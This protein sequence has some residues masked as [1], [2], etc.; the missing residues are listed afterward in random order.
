MEKGIYGLMALAACMTVS[1][2]SDEPSDNNIPR[3]DIELSRSEKEIVNSQQTFA[4]DLLNEGLEGNQNNVAFSP[5][6]ISVALSMTANGTEGEM[7]REILD[8]LHFDSNADLSVMN[9]CA[10][11]ILSELPTL[12]NRTTITTAQSVWTDRSISL[13]DGFREVCADVYH[14]SFGSFSGKEDG[15]AAIN[16]W[17][18]QNTNGMIRNA[19]QA[20]Y[21]GDLMIAN[22]TYF[23]GQWL[24]DFD[25]KKTKELSFTNAD[26]TR[27]LVNMMSDTKK[28]FY[29]WETDE[30]QMVTLPYGNG[31]FAMSIVL[32]TEGHTLAEVLVGMDSEEWSELKKAMV[33]CEV[34]LKMPRFTFESAGDIRD[35]LEEL[36][37]KR[38]WQNSATAMTTPA[39]MMHRF[40]HNIKVIV[41]EEGTVAASSSVA[42]GGF[43]A[44]IQP[45]DYV[46]M[47]CNHPFAFVIEEQS[48]GTIL[49]IGAV[50]RFQKR[51]T[52]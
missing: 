24:N 46:E 39:V 12:D 13:L 43:L 17:I 29:Y 23:K 52:L 1:S 28:D 16:D 45:G 35:T 10:G 40:I 14:A 11:R 15:A 36:G 21:V 44:N 19:M 38:L 33:K 18:S 22:A 25:K 30:L 50:N 20:S 27:E 48:T 49:F 7:Q 2:C 47:N 37:V 34:F 51:D 6:S 41:D 4:F 8:V 5:F 31:S 32:P 42:S 26:G 9:E 3:R